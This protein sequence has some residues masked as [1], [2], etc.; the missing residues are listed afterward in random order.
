MPFITKVL[1]KAIINGSRLRNNFLKNRTNKNLVL[2]TKQRHY[3]V[4]IRKSKKRNNYSNLTEKEIVDDKLFWKT[5]KPS[6]SVKVIARDG[7]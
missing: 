2:H 1:S 4:L 3:W 7:D 5:V 6:L